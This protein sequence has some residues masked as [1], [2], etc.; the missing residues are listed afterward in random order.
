MGVLE[1]MAALNSRR[2][3]R[4]GRSA[5]TWTTHGALCLSALSAPPA[6]SSHR[7]QPPRPAQ[8]PGGA[9]RRRSR[10]PT[11]Q[12]FSR[13]HGRSPRSAV[14]EAGWVATWRR[15]RASMGER[16]ATERQGFGLLLS[17]CFP[18]SRGAGEGS[19]PGTRVYAADA[20]RRPA[21]A[22]AHLCP[23]AAPPSSLQL[24]P[25]GVRPRGGGL[26]E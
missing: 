24:H 8:Q 20:R 23:A 25:Q 15:R 5:V 7:K 1:W 21:A 3:G 13:R 18:P 4:E 10:G 17:R 2:R 22:A 26:Q 11:P 6:R 16:R 14:V 19:L 9:R 12:E